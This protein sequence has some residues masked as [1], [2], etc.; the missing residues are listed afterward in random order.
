MT[1][2]NELNKSELMGGTTDRS[3]SIEYFP[4]LDISQNKIEDKL[5]LDPIMTIKNRIKGK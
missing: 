2:K 5:S 1:F 3:A 4:K